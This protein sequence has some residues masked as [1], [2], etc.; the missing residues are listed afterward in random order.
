MTVNYPVVPAFPG[1]PPLLRDPFAPAVTPVLST[2][3]ADNPGVTRQLGQS[4]TPRW[5]V[6]SNDGATPILIGDS[7][8]AVGYDK[9]WAVSDYPI[10]Q[11]QFQT[12]NKVARPRE[13]RV[14]LSKGGTKYD[15]ERFINQA[16]TCLDNTQSYAVVTP[17]RF[18]TDMNFVR[19]NY[20]RSGEDG[21][22]LFTVDLFAR[23]IRL[24]AQ[25]KFRNTQ[26]P[27][28][29]DATNQGTLTLK[30]PSPAQAGQLTGTPR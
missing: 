12:Y 27:N 19:M 15:R 10:E 21:P 16:G 13:M 24:T 3:S 25:T 6:Y 22:Q 30:D 5:G 20:D 28:D 2:L 1:V 8:L 9:E 11:G 7:V 18:Y 4:P 26:N 23:E 17:E 14:S 29:A